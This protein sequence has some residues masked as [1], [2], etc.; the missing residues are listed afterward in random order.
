MSPFFLGHDTGKLTTIARTAT[1]NSM[2]T[3]HKE[4]YDAFLEAGTSE[5]KA[6]SAAHAIA[7]V[8]EGLV[9]EESLKSA[10]S[11]LKYELKYEM[12]RLFTTGIGVVLAAIAALAIFK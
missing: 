10:L 2:S 6:E 11:E 8:P 3:I 12:Y 9:T 7:T 5:E 4:V 1:I